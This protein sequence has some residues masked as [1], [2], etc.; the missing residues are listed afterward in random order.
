MLQETFDRARG[1]DQEGNSNLVACWLYQA[2]TALDLA[3]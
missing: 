2:Y 3:G 1:A